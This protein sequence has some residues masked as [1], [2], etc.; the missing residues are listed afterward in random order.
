MKTITRQLSRVAAIE[1][2]KAYH[3]LPRMFLTLL[4]FVSAYLVTI[5]VNV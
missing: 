3:R 5:Q 4:V 1:T 2:M